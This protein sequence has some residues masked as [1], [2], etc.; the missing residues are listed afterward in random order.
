MEVV[1]I[2]RGG[3]FV[4]INESEQ[5]GVVE[6]QSLNET[7]GHGNLVVSVSARGENDY[8]VPSSLVS[9]NLSPGWSEQHTTSAVEHY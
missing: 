3:P 8:G 2:L 4:R 7:F 1:W 6:R 5:S 9:R